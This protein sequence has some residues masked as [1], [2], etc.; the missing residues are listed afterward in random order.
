MEPAV[1]PYRRP[2]S[3][4][5]HFLFC[6]LPTL[7]AAYVTCWRDDLKVFVA[8]R[9]KKIIAQFGGVGSVGVR[10]SFVTLWSSETG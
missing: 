10:S 2:R 8:F 3:Q 5:M 1:W 9:P 4:D 6:F 7:D